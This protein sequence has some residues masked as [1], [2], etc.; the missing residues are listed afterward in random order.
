MLQMFDDGRLTDGKGRLVDFKNTVIIMTRNI[1]SE[2][3]L[4]ETLTDEEKYGVLNYALREKFKP[5][6]LNRIDEIVMFKALTPDELAQ[7][8]DIQLYGLSKRLKEQGITF[9]I[10]DGAKKFLAREG[11]EPLYGARPLKRVIRQLV[12]IPLSVKILE[13]EFTKGSHVKIDFENGRLSLR[14]PAEVNLTVNP[15]RSNPGQL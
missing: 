1:G 7:I 4:D 14:A 5:E 6:F 10:T 11:Y 8:V 13:K 12:E 15:V 9:E 2:A 3:I